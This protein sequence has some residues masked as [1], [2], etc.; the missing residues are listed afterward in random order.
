MESDR[1]L[2][3]AIPNGRMA[4]VSL[5]AC[6]KERGTSRGSALHAW[7]GAFV[8]LLPDGC[9]GGSARGVRI[10]RPEK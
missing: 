9:S 2:R 7:A 3:H 4:G 1:K 5:P 8:R 10:R 6:S